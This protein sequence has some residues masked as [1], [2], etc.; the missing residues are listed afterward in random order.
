MPRFRPIPL[1]CPRPWR[2]GAAALGLALLVAL[3]AAA[4]IVGDWRDASGSSVITVIDTGA[5][6]GFSGA[7]DDGSV[8]FRG[9]LSGDAVEGEFRTATPDARAACPDTWIR[10]VPFEGTL[11]GDVLVIEVDFGTQNLETC[12]TAPSGRRSIVEYFRIAA[13][14]MTCP[15]PEGLAERLAT[16]QTRLDA[17]QRPRQLPP[18]FYRQDDPMGGLTEG[19]AQ[20]RQLVDEMRGLGFPD[21]AI[22][23]T[24]EADAAA[25]RVI[26]L[27]TPWLTP[28]QPCDRDVWQERAR[29]IDR[30]FQRFA[31]HHNRVKIVERNVITQ[32]GHFSGAFWDALEARGMVEEALVGVGTTLGFDAETMET[33]YFYGN[34]VATLNTITGA[35]MDRITQIPATGF[36]MIGAGFM[37]LKAIGALG[38]LAEA[39]GAYNLYYPALE[40]IELQVY[41][42]PLAN[43]YTGIDN[44]VGALRETVATHYP[45]ER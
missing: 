32:M 24:G 28:D 13:D 41:V 43:A 12:A 10:F 7:F 14:P 27:V 16:L 20:A 26:A 31:L 21:N 5:A 34:S 19:L 23:P 4:D 36:T 29:E 38:D 3:P 17:A 15:P 42:T 25:R 30:A 8:L 2:R 22:T 6:G 40:Y 1:P 44:A 39:I 33:L 37:T 18:L 45:V 9:T 35:I 11:S